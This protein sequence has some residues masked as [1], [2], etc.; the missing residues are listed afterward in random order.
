MKEE[1]RQNTA[2][3]PQDWWL[4]VPLSAQIVTFQTE[5]SLDSSMSDTVDSG[6]CAFGLT[7]IV[8]IKYVCEWPVAVL[9]W[10]VP[11]AVVA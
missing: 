9:C 10:T 5:G 7:S 11:N 3:P 8:N 4:E 6:H 2:Q 1:N